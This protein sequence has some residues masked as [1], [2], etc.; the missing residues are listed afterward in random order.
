MFPQDASARQS[1]L[2]ELEKTFAA[3]KKRESDSFSEDYATFQEERHTALKPEDRN[4]F[5]PLYIRQEMTAVLRL[6][7]HAQK[8]IAAKN[9]MDGLELIEATQMSDLR[10]RQAQDMKLECLRAL[11]RNAEADKLARENFLAWP[12]SSFV[13]R[14][15]RFFGMIANEVR[16]IAADRTRK[17]KSSK[18]KP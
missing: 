5:N 2:M 15:F 3:L 11:G 17:K 9:Y 13:R 1:A 16:S 4:R 8:N 7:S 12:E 14:I 10:L 6:L 18:S